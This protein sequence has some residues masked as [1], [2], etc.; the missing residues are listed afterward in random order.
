MKLFYRKQGKGRNVIILHGLFG[1]SDNW[2]SVAKMLA[3]EYTVWLIDQRNHG[4]SPHADEFSYEAMARD[5]NDF[6][7]EHNIR[8]PYLI[9]HSMGGKTVIEFLISRH[10]ML[11]GAIIADIGPKFYPVHHQ[12]ILEGLNAIDMSNVKSRKDIEDQLKTYIS[13]FGIRAFLLKNVKRTEAGNYEWMINLPVITRD[14]ENVGKGY[15]DKHVYMG[16]VLFVRGGKS[17]YIKDE[18][19]DLIKRIFPKAELETIEKAGHWLHAE[20]PEEFV[21]LVKKYF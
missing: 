14:I 9:G 8:D 11:P 16:E 15:S 20:Q 1:S 10:T 13:D 2:M 6:I 5:L 12:Q 19:F 21:E 3:N 18:D 7:E 4:Q 17:D